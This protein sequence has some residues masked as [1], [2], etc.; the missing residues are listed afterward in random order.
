[1]TDGASLTEFCQQ[2]VEQLRAV[3]VLQMTN[4]PALLDDLPAETVQQMQAQA[5]QM[6]LAMTLY[7]IKRF[8]TAASEL[9]GGFQ[10]QLPLEMALIEVVQGAIQA[11]AT[12]IVQAAAP[13][14]AMEKAT[15]NTTILAAQPQ[16][17]QSAT[18]AT[19]TQSKP[20]PE[21]VAVDSETSR[22]LWARW[23]D[24][25]TVVRTQ[26]GQQAAAGLQAV[27]D[28]A[29]SDHV[30]ALAFG[31]N[32]FSR[33]LVAKPDVLPGVAVALSRFMGREVAIECQ[34]GDTAVLVGQPGIVQAPITEGPDPLVEYAVQDLGAQVTQNADSPRKRRSSPAV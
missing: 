9:K 34:I 22:R 19:E 2:V 23:K 17:A 3:M 24:F 12:V 6:D 25:I 7:A 8:S 1:M 15:Q 32:E 10:P 30:V 4:N 28:V 16:Q 11:P 31:S 27:R 14:V 26:C 21:S 5:Q 18:A 33:N 29:V 20:K 13:A